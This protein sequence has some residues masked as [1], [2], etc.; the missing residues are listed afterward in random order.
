[1]RFTAGLVLGLAVGLVFLGAACGSGTATTTDAA[2]FGDAG[3][4]SCT[5]VQFF[6]GGTATL[7]LETLADVGPSFQQTCAQN[8][9]SVPADAGSETFVDGPCSRADAL[10][11]CQTDLDGLIENQWYYGSGGDSG[12]SVFG[13]TA[14]DI[15]MLCDLMSATYLPP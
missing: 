11:A 5:I 4:A 8:A 6:D 13:Q 7:C 10:G 3:V 2:S 14:S 9:A 12:T 1:M 15:K